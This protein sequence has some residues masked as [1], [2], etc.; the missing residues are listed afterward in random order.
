MPPRP[1]LPQQRSVTPAMLR[2]WRAMET[3][4]LACRAQAARR[5]RCTWSRTNSGKACTA[6]GFA[7]VP[8][9]HHRNSA[10]TGVTHKVSCVTCHEELWE[11]AQKENKTEE[12]ARLG[13]VA[14]QIERSCI[15]YMRVRTGMIS[16]IPTQPAITATIR[17]TFTPT[18]VR[19]QSVAAEHPQYLRQVP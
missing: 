3:K 15:R 2:A 13:V 10:Q 4:A 11:A 8:Q 16:R 7:R 5:A 9:G 6:S 12:H 14:K 1:S 19:A 17:I 18:A